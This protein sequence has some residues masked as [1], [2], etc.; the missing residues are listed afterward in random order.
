MN[1]KGSKT[2]VNLRNAFIGE[3]M[4]RCR[5]MYYAEKAREEGKEDVAAAY[6]R[7][8]RN[9]Q[10]HAKIWF[11]SFH[12]I[13]TT[14]ENLKESIINENYES[15][16]MYLS[17]AKT[18]QEEGFDELAMAFMNVA[19][20]EDGHKKQFQSL[21]RDSK[22]DIPSWQCDICGYTDSESKNPAICP[23]CKHKIKK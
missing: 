19:R 17:Y 15:I 3:A 11:E 13:P 9:E 6:E 1:L 18:A 8:A 14:E 10:E 2:E 7:F 22:A 4:A 20:I 5:Y 23:V 16:D 21:L 12:G